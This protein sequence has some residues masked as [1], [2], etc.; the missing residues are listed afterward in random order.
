MLS[1]LFDKVT[2]LFDRRFTVALLLPAFALAAGCGALAATMVGWHR[3]VGW[4]SALHGASQLTLGVAAAAG[5][6]LLAIL[7]GTQVVAMTRLLQGYWW[8][9]VHRTL[10][11][12]GRALEQQRLHRLEK[13]ASAEGYQR[14]YTAFPA[15]AAMIMPTR[16]GNALRAAESYPGDEERWGIDSGF[17]WPRLYL[18]LPDGA[19]GQ[20]DEARAGLDQM[21]V[22]TWLSA[23][24]GLVS[25]ALGGAGLSWTVAGS[26]AGGALLLSW[27]SYRAAVSSAA[28]Y[29]DLLRSCYDLYRGD[30]LVKLGW[31]LP[32]TLKEERQLWETLGQQFYRRGVSG[33]NQPLIDAPR[34]KPTGPPAAT[35]E[36]GATDPADAG[37]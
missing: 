17:W 6:V 19:R 31:S 14:L 1:T 11:A 33:E 37:S 29:G 16:L 9:P 36:S 22:L 21:V 24:F 28:A 7:A 35:P 18:I 2:G 5:V 25:L 20:V 3:I 15:D 13:D 4:W 8:R 27:F 32:P 26:C 12:F 30:L 34:I 10:G 23:G